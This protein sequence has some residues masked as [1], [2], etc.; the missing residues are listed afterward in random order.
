MARYE[1][2]APIAD[3]LL[4]P[5]GS[6]VTISGLMVLPADP[7]RAKIYEN[8]VPAAAKWILPDGTIVDTLPTS[9]G[10][11]GT[12]NYNDLTNKPSIEGVVLEGALTYTSLGIASKDD[13]SNLASKQD[14]T[15]A[16]AGLATEQYVTASIKGAID[17]SW[18]GAY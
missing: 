17:D 10:G 18:E 7:E 13:I 5:D 2:M 11:G 6:V 3:K 15:D 12:S 9:G 4:K 8:R 1:D 16:V 14:V